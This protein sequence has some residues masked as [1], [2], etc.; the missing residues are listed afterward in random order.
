M[1]SFSVPAVFYSGNSLILT[2]LVCYCNRKK[3]L[4]YLLK[5]LESILI[6][7]ITGFLPLYGSF[8]KASLQQLLQMLRNGALSRRQ[9]LYDFSTDTGWMAS[10]F[11][12]NGDSRRVRQGFS[13]IRQILIFLLKDFFLV[14]DHVRILFIAKLRCC[15]KIQSKIIVKLRYERVWFFR[16]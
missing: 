12:Q 1:I 14:S 15:F 16:T 2:A 6:D 9:H 13:K 11:F 5:L 8:D 3:G 7:T 4:Q 10:Q